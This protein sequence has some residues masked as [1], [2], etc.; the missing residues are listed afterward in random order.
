VVSTFR[1]QSISRGFRVAIT[2]ACC[3]ASA[4][5]QAPVERDSAGIRIVENPS[6]ATAPVVFRLGAKAVEVG[7][8]ATDLDD[9][10]NARRLGTFKGVR[11]S[12]GSLAVINAVRVQLYD[13]RGNKTGVFGRTG[14]GPQEF[15]SLS[16]VEYCRTRGD[17]LVAGD[18]RNGRIA[19]IH[20]RTVVKTIPLSAE[21]GGSMTGCFDDG[22]MLMQGGLPNFKTPTYTVRLHRVRLDG[23]LVNSLGTIVF[24]TPSPVAGLVHPSVAV[25]GQRVYAGD[26]A[27]SEIR[28][29]HADGRLLQIIRSADLAQR[30][31]PA[32]VERAL[33][34][35]TAA[36]RDMWRPA[37]YPTFLRLLADP[38]GRLWVRDF[39]PAGKATE[40]DGWTAFDSNGRLIGRLE[41]PRKIG[42][43]SASVL[44]FGAGEVQLVERDED[45]FYHLAF[46]PIVQHTR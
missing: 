5:A 24:R 22:T 20:A 9:E 32:D 30:I 38:D 42:I 41:V 7:G 17:T 1:S 34:R 16:S 21:F 25:A 13:A 36:Q 12:D 35:S 4:A 6:R 10:F 29:Y 8:P 40:A 23:T 37:T 26:G 2:W 14:A 43:S 44:A 15:V 28:V 19:I 11:M 33:G 31:A 27:T 18:Y 3:A 45:G 39:P 46:Y